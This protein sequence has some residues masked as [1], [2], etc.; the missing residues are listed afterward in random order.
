MKQIDLTDLEMARKNRERIANEGDP[1]AGHRSKSSKSRRPRIANVAKKRENRNEVQRPLEPLKD[2]EPGVTTEE[3]DDF[4]QKVTRPMAKK[5]ARKGNQNARKHGFYSKQPEP[6]AKKIATITF[7]PNKK[8][9][10]ITRVD[11]IKEADQPTE[12]V[13]PYC[14]KAMVIRAGRYGK[15]LACSSWPACGKE[16]EE[17]GQLAQDSGLSSVRYAL[18]LL[19]VDTV[20]AF[21]HRFK[22]R[23]AQYGNRPEVAEDAYMEVLVESSDLGNLRKMLLHWAKYLGSLPDCQHTRGARLALAVL[24]D[25]CRATDMNSIVGEIGE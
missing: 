10:E 24:A 5:G 22:E 20:E 8:S 12:E 19:L 3:F 16:V 1:E 23:C 7:N 15:F 25:L 9:P 2:Y 13:C 6:G 21:K 4:L 18:N 14:G 11:E 17:K